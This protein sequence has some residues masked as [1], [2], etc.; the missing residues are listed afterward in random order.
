MTS[1]TGAADTVA[2]LHAVRQRVERDF[3]ADEPLTRTA[4]HLI[5]C[6]ADVVGRLPGGDVDSTREALAAARAA[7]ISATYAVRRAHDRTR[8]ERP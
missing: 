7:V 1:P 4:L 2:R 5:D 6:A 3:D 8:T